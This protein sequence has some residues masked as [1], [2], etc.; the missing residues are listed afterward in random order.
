MSKLNENIL[1]KSNISIPALLLL[2]VFLI[3]GCSSTPPC[4]KK[5]MVGTTIDWGFINSNENSKENSIKGNLLD[6]NGMV[7]KYIMENDSIRFIGD[8]IKTDNEK[9]C[10]TF[11]LVRQHLINTQ[12]LFEPSDEQKFLRYKNPNFNV[13][14][15][16]V[17][18]PKYE[19][20]GSEKARA[21]YD[22]L[23]VLIENISK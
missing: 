1:L 3:F 14:I 4:I 15:R 2:T 17:W 16:V 8:P 10:K 7:R 5:G 21:A 23:N 12:A 13:D 19:T 6:H 20:A 18:N 9:F 22:S 11:T